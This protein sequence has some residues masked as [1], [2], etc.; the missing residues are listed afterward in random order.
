MSRG[1]KRFRESRGI[2]LFDPFWVRLS[3]HEG[4]WAVGQESSWIVG[5]RGSFDNWVGVL[6]LNRAQIELGFH[7][8]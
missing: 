2:G 6:G 8:I 1:C 7:Q 5:L 3:V 4:A